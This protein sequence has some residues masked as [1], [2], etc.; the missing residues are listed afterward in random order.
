M[1]SIKHLIHVI[2]GSYKFWWQLDT[3]FTSF[4]YDSVPIVGVIRQLQ[5]RLRIRASAMPTRYI[6]QHFII[7]S[8]PWKY[9]IFHSHLFI[10]NN[11]LHGEDCFLESSHKFPLSPPSLWNPKVYYC[12][13]TRLLLYPIMS[14]ISPT[15]DL[16]NFLFRM[17]FN[18]I[19]PFTPTFAKWPLWLLWIYI[20][21]FLLLIL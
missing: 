4:P 12:I 5:G 2:K 10:T 18:I 8:L 13:Q 15:H 9:K 19:F 3:P 7:T 21:E 6:D 14:Q 16:T 1:T 17:C 11:Q 20:G